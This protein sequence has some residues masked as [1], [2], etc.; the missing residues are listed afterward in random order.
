MKETH[1]S[2]IFQGKTPKC[3]FERKADRRWDA[4]QVS[5]IA[6]SDF[7]NLNQNTLTIAT[8]PGGFLSCA[9]HK[10]SVASLVVIAKDIPQISFIFKVNI[11]KG[12]I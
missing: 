2:K 12:D 1:G 6:S 4:M 10:T 11:Y 7:L 8:Y 3:F 5:H 9:K